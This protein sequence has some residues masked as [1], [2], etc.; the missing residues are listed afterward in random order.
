LIIIGHSTQRE[1]M[2]RLFCLLF[3]SASLSLS[4]D[5]SA[6]DN[7]RE[8][9]SKEF[10][11][12]TGKVRDEKSGDEL[13]GAS[14][15]IVNTKLG[16]ASDIDGRFEIQQVP[17]GK[18]DIRVSFLGYETKLITGLP[19]QA[20]KRTVIDVGL[21]EDQG[22]VQQEVVINADVI[23]SGEGAILAERKK[24]IVIGDGI[25][26]EQIKRAPDATSGDAL[27]RVPGV[28][29]VDNK[30]VFVRGTSERYSNTT[31]N[32]A[33]LSGAEPEK[34]SFS[35]DMFPSNLLENIVIAKTFTPDMQGDFSGGNVQLSTVDFPDYLTV[36]LSIGNSFNSAVTTK[37]FTTYA[38]GKT[39][40]LGMDDGTRALP[41]GIPADF[42]KGTIPLSDQQKYA[43]LFPNNWAPKT[44]K[45]PINNNFELSIG[46]A[47]PLFDESRF[48]FIAALTYKNNFSHSNI[49]RNDYE[50]DRSKYLY[51]GTRDAFS[52]L[53][54]GMLNMSY[55]VTPFH[56][57]SLK[58]VYNRTS[59]DEV[60]SL[61]GLY[62][63]RPSL[64]K[65]TGFRFTERS[66]FSTQLIGEHV[67]VD[68][69]GLQLQWRAAN[70]ESNR[71]EPDSRRVGYFKDAN[72]PEEPYYAVVDF[73]AQ[74]RSGGRFY[75]SLNDIV[76]NYAADITL[77]VGGMKIKAGGLYE[78]KDRIFNSRLIAFVRPQPGNPFDR[79][80][81]Q[82]AIDSLFS[83]ENVKS[84]GF[85]ISEYS[86]GSNNYTAGHNVFA[87]Y[88]MADIPLTVLTQHFRLTTGARVENFIQRISS[89]YLDNSPIDKSVQHVDLLPSVNL[90]YLLA[91][92]TNV[93]VAYSQTVN[94]PELRELAPFPYYDFTTQ[95]TVYGNDKLRRAL[96]KNY[97]VRYEFFPNPGEIISVSYFYKKLTDAIEMVNVPGSALGSDRTFDN[98]NGVNYGYEV[99][100]RTS[101]RHISYLLNNFALMGNYTKVHSK[102]TTLTGV[103]LEKKD[104]PLQGQSPYVINL[105]LL[106][107]MPE[108]GFS[109]SV[110][111][112]K[113]GERISEASTLASEDIRE[114]P[115]NVVDITLTKT[116]LQNYELKFSAKDLF[117]EPQVYKVQQG[118]I[119]QIVRSNSVGIQYSLGISYKL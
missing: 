1:I 59:E 44:I 50:A 113:F 104:R 82:Y 35:F 16:T 83:P 4:Q 66:I 22:V 32:G 93:R 7:T 112:H 81:L 70:S 14:I 39:D 63:D 11:V 88:A 24:S 98:A 36:R 46:N 101:L 54:G 85:R 68:L 119:D 12:I 61:A 90:T 38:G 20:N 67:F 48:G 25:S 6:L 56:K 116:V 52:V 76:R 17:E 9:S 57:I 43:A 118:T 33:T 34:K 91:E 94:R 13:I 89:F 28:T 69:N 47:Y 31:L 73:Q 27:K 42:T 84:N 77:P 40:W 108:Y 45:A 58:N 19:V 80:L 18:T 8:R 114:M 110:M 23:R 74:T 103:G 87:Y 92:N 106:L 64:V 5:F 111:F 51:T 29:I 97:D 86:N 15:S 10:G 53:W 65:N 95:L 71:A 26:A 37:S 105:S 75:S 41:S 107:T 96:I 21:R 60:V 109:T 30:F 2:K 100:F 3:V 62:N 99:E 117:R 115:R 55:K 102:V 49:E 79:S 72:E 78:D